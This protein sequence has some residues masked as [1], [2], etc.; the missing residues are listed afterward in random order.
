MCKFIS[1]SKHSAVFDAKNGWFLLASSKKSTTNKTYV[2]FP[3][4]KEL[5]DK[6]YICIN[7]TES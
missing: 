3:D 1:C 6:D 7:R 2:P 5:Q 4:P